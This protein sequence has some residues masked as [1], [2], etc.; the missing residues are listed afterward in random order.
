MNKL[1]LFLI[2]FSA[3]S[4][5][6]T[7]TRAQSYLEKNM[8]PSFGF[9]FGVNFPSMQGDMDNMLK[10]LGVKTRT[11]LNFGA[12]VDFPLLQDFY[13]QSGLYFVTKGFDVKGES[14]THTGGGLYLKAHSENRASY[15][16]V[17]LVFSVR[18]CLSNKVRLHL[19][20]GAFFA[21]GIEG[22]QKVKEISYYGY[23]ASQIKD[24][25][26]RNG[27][28]FGSNGD[29]NRFDFGAVFATGVSFYKCYLGFQ[30]ERGLINVGKYN[31][32]KDVEYNNRRPSFRTS[33]ISLVTG[34]TF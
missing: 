23:S 2:A 7:H 28:Y 5:V 20:L 34:Y 8:E 12:I 4:L 16:Q 10:G 29:Y 30:Y 15:L 17:P 33:N 24:M 31:A 3:I 22:T 32:W 9:R 19:D 1:V 26:I 27:K 13:L 6:S 14:G 21:Y 18:P 25:G 11:Q